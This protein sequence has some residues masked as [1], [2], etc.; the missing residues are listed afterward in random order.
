MKTTWAFE[1]FVK[2]EYPYAKLMNFLH[3]IHSCKTT[4]MEVRA[5][6]IRLQEFWIFASVA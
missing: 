1:K 4:L 5:E 2:S 6:V 3:I